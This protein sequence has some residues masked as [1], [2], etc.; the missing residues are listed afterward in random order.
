LDAVLGIFPAG[1]FK[2]NFNQ[3]P[4]CKVIFGQYALTRNQLPEKA[5]PLVRGGRKAPGLCTKMAGL[6][7][8]KIPR[9]ARPFTVFGLTRQEKEDG[10]H[11][12]PGS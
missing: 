3:K 5:K 11:S 1:K 8:E 12:K 7:K 4:A 10:L 9:I 6:P 2:V